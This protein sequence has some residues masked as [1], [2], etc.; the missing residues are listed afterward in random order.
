MPIFPT[1]RRTIVALAVLACALCALVAARPAPGDIV[2]PAVTLGPTTIA[3]GTAIVSGT[4]TSSDPSSSTLTVNGQPLGVTSDGTFAGTVDLSG[5]SNLSLAV[6]NPADGQVSTVTIPLTTNLVGS[7]GVVS[8]TA[9]SGLEQ[10]AAT[11]TEPVGGFVSVGG[12]PISVGGSV[13]NRDQLAGLS[14]N[15]VD[16]LSTLSPDG[17]FSTRVPGTSREV[18]VLMTDKQGVSLEQRYPAAAPAHVSAANA[19]GI[20][21]ASVR[22]YTKAVKTKQR[23]RMV[24][25][26]QDRRGL[27][28]RGARVTVRTLRSA[29]VVGGA[30]AKRSNK[31]GQAGFVLRL[32]PKAFGKRLVIITTVRTPTAKTSKR[33]SVRVPRRGSR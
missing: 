6:S 26:V 20:R 29:R 12:E 21:I 32:R 1:N 2:A 7:G 27:S 11:I 24:V 16:A 18:T 4:I 17:T 15:G 3:N 19:V 31:Q 25:A 5:Q 23:L 22:Y 9:L 14:V 10:A 28:V 13:G 33:T 30:K 8:P